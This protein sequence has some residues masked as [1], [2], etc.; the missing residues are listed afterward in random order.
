MKFFNKTSQRDE[1]Q[2]RS[3]NRKTNKFMPKY[4]VGSK[5]LDEPG[6]LTEKEM[7]LRKIE[8]SVKMQKDNLGLGKLFSP[9]QERNRK[10]LN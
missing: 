2:Q 6:P 8:A 1:K 3:E 10:L 5:L 7:A 4:T 9:Y